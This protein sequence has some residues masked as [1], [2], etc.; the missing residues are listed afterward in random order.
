M[1]W[2]QY[3]DNPKPIT[4]IYQQLP[5][6][7]QVRI[8]EA[9]LLQDG[10]EVLLRIDLNEFPASPPLKWIAGK[11]NRVQ[12]KLS[13]IDV[14]DVQIAGWCTDNVGN[15]EISQYDGSLR[16]VFNSPACKLRCDAKFIHIASISAYC[17]SSR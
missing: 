5:V 17:D 10:P 1:S 9:Q 4:S 3:V 12:M 8:L 7:Q 13:L 15:I 14:S 16:V 11:F 6:L 2:I